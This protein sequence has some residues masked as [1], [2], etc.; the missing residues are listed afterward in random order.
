[1]PAP[2]LAY[3]KGRCTLARVEQMHQKYARQRALEIEKISGE[4]Y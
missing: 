1:M 3:E 4:D 2:A